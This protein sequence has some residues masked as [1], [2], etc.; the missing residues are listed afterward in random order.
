MQYDFIHHPDG[1]IIIQNSDYT[2]LFWLMVEPSYAIP[3]NYIGRLFNIG[4][5]NHLI[6]IGNDT[7]DQGDINDAILTEYVNKK[8]EYDTAY[9]AYNNGAYIENIDGI[10]VITG[11][12]LLTLD[13]EEIS[14]DGI[15]TITVT[16]DLGDIE[17]VDEIR[18]SVTA[19]DGSIVSEADFAIGGI[20]Q[21][22]LT[23]SFVGLHTVRVETDFYGS[24]DIV[25]NGV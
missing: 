23:T 8:V 25:F 22:P 2:M 13:K 14:N 18:W 9:A 21:W 5:A 17:A 11:P 6:R 16:C 24:K 15:D 10:I 7:Y 12:P 19:S 3:N 1:K 20:D 4:Q